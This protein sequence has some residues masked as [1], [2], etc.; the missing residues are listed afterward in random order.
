MAHFNKL[1]CGS[2]KN[3]EFPSARFNPP[4]LGGRALAAL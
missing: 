4:P 3:V 2:L 1:S